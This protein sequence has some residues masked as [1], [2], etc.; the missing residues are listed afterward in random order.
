MTEQIDGYGAA[1]KYISATPKFTKKNSM[2]NTEKFLAHLGY[3]AQN[4]KILHVAG[5]NGKGSVCAYLSTVLRKAGISCGMFVSPHLV[6]MRE[7]FVI[8][9]EMV[10]EEAFLESFH[11]VI[12]I[13]TS[14]AA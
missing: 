5:T 8:D 6:T 2:D 10:T 11:I 7:R 4:C 13:F 1:Q 3:P 9:G 12:F 14:V